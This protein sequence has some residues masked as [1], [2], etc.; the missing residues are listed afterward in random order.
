MH[1]AASR[2]IGFAFAALFV[3]GFAGSAWAGDGRIEVSQSCVD[4]PCIPG[5]PPGFPIFLQAGKNYVL[6]SDIVLPDA[7]Q[8]AFGMGDYA[9]LDLNGFRIRG[10]T[11]CTGDPVTSCTNAGSGDGIIGGTGAVVRNGVIQGMGDHGI[12]TGDAMR[13]EDLVIEQCGGSGIRANTGN[14]ALLI[15]RNRIQRNGEYGISISPG[16]P[17]DATLIRDNVITG[18]R[19]AGVSGR[20]FLALGNTLVRNAGAG[21]VVGGTGTSPT[22]YGG[23]VIT[24]NSGQTETGQVAGGL[25]VGANQCGEDTTCP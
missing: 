20:G 19:L 1:R 10:V 15:R 25:Q 11:T 13:I 24:G 22:G 21:L 14:D 18:N 7:V 16:G 3:L 8:T 12:A 9:R 17:A 6:T 2:G 23:N 4:T 5:D